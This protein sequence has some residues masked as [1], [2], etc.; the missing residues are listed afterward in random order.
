MKNSEHPLLQT[1]LNLT[2]ECHQSSD[3]W[4]LVSLLPDL[5]VSDLEKSQSNLYSFVVYEWAYFMT[6]SKM[7]G[8][9]FNLHSNLGCSE[10]FIKQSVFEESSKCPMPTNKH[11][12][13]RI[14]LSVA[15]ELLNAS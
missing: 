6:L 2:L 15:G 1:I 9:R 7:L 13:Q 4:M 5:E 8:D 3:S 11:P 12:G 14:P 10:F